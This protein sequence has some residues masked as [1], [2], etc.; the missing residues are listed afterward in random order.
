MEKKL[1]LTLGDKKKVLEIS[2]ALSN[3]ARLDILELLFYESLSV[4]EISKKLNV[5]LTSVCSNIAVLE[6]SG[7]EVKELGILL[8][9]KT[10]SELIQTVGNKITLFRQRKKDSKIVLP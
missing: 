7:F 5:P 10:N 3:P 6:N 2:K 4:D 9:N 1:N 8:A